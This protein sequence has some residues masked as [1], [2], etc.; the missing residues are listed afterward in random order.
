MLSMAALGCGG[1]AAELS[2]LICECEHCNDWEEDETLDAYQASEDVAD[3]YGCADLWDAYMTCQIDEGSC[4]ETDANWSLPQSGGSCSGTMDT[5]NPCTMDADCAGQGT[6]SATMTCVVSTCAGGGGQCMTDQDCP[7][8]N[9]CQPDD[10][11]L[12][13]CIEK[14][15]AHGGPSGPNFP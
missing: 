10:D 14:G 3:A 5:G 13:D 2:G 12:D 11:R 7:G 1:P 15:S 6:C 4:D 9:P 8:V